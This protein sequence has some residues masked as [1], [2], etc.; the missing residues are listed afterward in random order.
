MR[1]RILAKPRLALRLKTPGP[2]PARKRRFV[3]ELR[4]RV[5]ACELPVD[6]HRVS[7]HPPAPGLRLPP[8][9]L[10]I[11]HSTV[12]G[13]LSGEQADLDLRLI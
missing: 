13:T 12:P 10:Q 7:I 1:I 4:P 5:L 9:S 6:F 11:R 2:R 3:A 8:Q